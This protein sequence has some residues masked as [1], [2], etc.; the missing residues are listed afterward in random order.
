MIYHLPDGRKVRCE[1]KRRY[2]LIAA[3]SDGRPFVVQRS[4]DATKLRRSR[5]ALRSSGYVYY[6]GD[7]F[8]GRVERIDRDAV[9]T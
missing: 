7:R 8:D 6:L 3:P 5:R 2:A 4:D 9:I 1:S